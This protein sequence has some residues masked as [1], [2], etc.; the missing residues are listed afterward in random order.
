MSAQPAASFA[1]AA[2]GR[3]ELRDDPEP[4]HNDLIG[5]RTGLARGLRT[6]VAA[7]IGADEIGG[8]LRLMIGTSGQSNVFSGVSSELSSGNAT[9]TTAYPNVQMARKLDGNTD[10]PVWTEIFKQALAPITYSGSP[11]FGPELTMMRDLDSGS[12]GGFAFSSFAGAGTNLFTQWLPTGTYPA[13]DGTGVNYF[14][15]CVAYY[16]A[17]EIE[18]GAK[19]TVL[20]WIQGEGD[21]GNLSAANA[22]QTNLLALIDAFRVYWP[23]LIFVIGRLNSD[24]V[25]AAGNVGQYTSTIQAAQ[26]AVAIART[27]VYLVNPDGVPLRAD[28]THYPGDSCI[29]LGHSYAG[30]VANALGVNLPPQAS[31]TSSSTGLAATFTDTSIA[32]GSSISSWS[33]TFGDGGTSTSQN[34]SHS[35]SG[36]GSYTVSLTVTAAN[37]KTNTYSTSVTI[38]SVA[39]TVDPT[40]NLAFPANAT[41][42]T[43]FISGNSLTNWSNPNSL[44]NAQDAAPPLGDTIGSTTLPLVGAGGL[45]QQAVPGLTRKGAALTEGTSG[46]FKSTSASLPDISVTSCLKLAWIFFPSSAPAANRFVMIVGTNVSI[47]WTTAKK[48]IGSSGSNS[49]TGTATYSSVLEPCIIKENHTGL[50]TAIYTSQEKIIPTHG[51]ATGKQINL[52]S[53]GAAAGVTYPYAARWDGAAAERSDVDVKALLQAFGKTVP[54]S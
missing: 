14:H 51:A 25:N 28:H 23:G 47:Q 18:L 9:Y 37:G 6:S 36:S 42:W 17:K 39:W 35:Y 24:Y 10:P 49:T 48:I 8:S 34:P 40:A 19:L 11:S 21:A 16:Q 1:C 38:S 41:E 13:L 29:T 12:P 4:Q 44:Y 5:L 50:V 45:Y 15:Q 33:W 2:Q 3:T 31:F 7:G 22:Y 30:K 27:G 54:W 53:G 52:G 32:P 43:A 46:G 20:V 26:D